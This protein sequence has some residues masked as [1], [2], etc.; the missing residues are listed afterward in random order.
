MSRFY[1]LLLIS[2]LL[3]TQAG[4]AIEPD[5][6]RILADLKN[7]TLAELGQVEIRLDETFDIFDGLVRAKK[8][9]IATGTTQYA[10]RAPAVTSVITAQ[11]IEAMGARTLEDILQSVP[12]LQVSYNWYNIPIYSIRGISSVYNP[13]ILVLLN[14]ARMSDNYTGSK[15]VFWSGIPVSTISRVE[16]IRGPGS[17][18]YGAD[19]FAG[20]INIVTKSGQEIDGTEAGFRIGNQNTQD[21]WLLHGHEWNG[22][23]LSAMLNFGNTDGHRRIVESDAQTYWDQVL[24]TNVSDAPGHYGSEITT[25]DARFDIAKDNW[26][27][28]AGVHKAD[29]MGAGTGVAQALDDRQPMQDRKINAELIYNNQDL[30]ENWGVKANFNYLHTARTAFFYAFPEGAFGGA[31]PIGYIGAPSNYSE[32]SQLNLSAIYRGFKGHQIQLGAGYGYYD[33]YKVTAT[34]NFGKNPFAE[35]RIPT[36]QLLDISDT[37]YLFISENARSS[38]FAFIQDSW[39]IDT[40][41]EL[42]TGLR[43]DRYSDFGSVFNP[44]LGLVWEADEDLIV[45]LLYGEAFR[46]PAFQELYTQNNP[47][48]LGNPD[49]K[50]E[51]VKTWELVFNYSLHNDLNFA[52]NLFRYDIE[53]KIAIVPFGGSEHGFGNEEKWRGMGGEFEMRWKTSSKSSLLF[54]YSYQSSKNKVTD[55]DLPSAPKQTAFARV[56]YLLGYKWYLDTQL[57][58]NDGWTR[59]PNDYRADLDG[60]TTVDFVLRYKD[61]RKGKTN[62]AIGVKNLL[63][64][65]VRYPSPEPD[66]GSTSVMIPNDLPG[67][68]RFYFLEFRYKF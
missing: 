40:N 10:D 18:L 38:W 48:T 17:A 64:A 61:I 35:G 19:A 16:V 60:Y 43:Y 65:D 33:M 34:Q 22:F 31:Y 20:V 2:G 5:D 21:I 50:P 53:D 66:I 28:R 63:D 37:P 26:R 45:K 47:V 3:C 32:N 56:D 15:G 55:L 7:L 25:Y 57:N 41:W 54:N 39:A 68:D 59:P 44:R 27:L 46:A 62:F 42:T 6:E 9:A 49:L 36:T 29:D 51:K 24:D 58:W 4:L 11:D 1:F 8:T 30:S 12:G 67:A 23:E 52:L 13:E 14:G